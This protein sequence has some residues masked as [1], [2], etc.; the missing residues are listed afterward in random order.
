MAGGGIRDAKVCC[1]I[2]ARKLYT[3]LSI[4]VRS[5]DGLRS[6][7]GLPSGS[8]SLA[9]TSSYSNDFN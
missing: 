5:V 4:C 9:M 3:A 6:K 2:S 8:A 7:F 1:V